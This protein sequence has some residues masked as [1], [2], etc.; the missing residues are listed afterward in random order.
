M[1]RTIVRQWGSQKV[2]G[3]KVILRVSAVLTF[4]C[5]KNITFKKERM[6]YN[7]KEISARKASDF[8]K[9]TRGCKGFDGGVESG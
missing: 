4:F 8:K 5:K 2:H 9:M 7:K 6:W 3:R 1:E